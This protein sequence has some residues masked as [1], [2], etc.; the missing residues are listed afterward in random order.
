MREEHVLAAERGKPGAREVRG[1][2]RALR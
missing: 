2:H 1:V